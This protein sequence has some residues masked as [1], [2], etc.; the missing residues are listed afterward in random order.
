MKRLE[1]VTSDKVDTKP[2]IKC[3]K[4]CG[5]CTLKDCI[6]VVITKEG[7]PRTYRQFYKEIVE[8]L[9]IQQFGVSPSYYA[10]SVA[11]VMSTVA[12]FPTSDGWSYNLR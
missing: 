9:M 5:T 2:P 10:V 6:E 1:F 11:T 12:S 3:N 7:E 8:K 4:I